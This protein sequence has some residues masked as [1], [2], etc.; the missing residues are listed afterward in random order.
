MI[1]NSNFLVSS[2]KHS[3]VSINVEKLEAELLSIY[4]R[5]LPKIFSG[6]VKV[7]ENANASVIEP[8]SENDL[9]NSLL[10]GI[11]KTLLKNAVA[12]MGEYHRE[13][14]ITHVDANVKRNSF[15]FPISIVVTQ[16]GDK[17]PDYTVHDHLFPEI[18]IH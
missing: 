16:K 3:N 9:L 6:D 14:T 2:T 15:K 10:P 12:E 1:T 7:K 11:R 5:L 13:E 18:V 8:F 4:K 17:E